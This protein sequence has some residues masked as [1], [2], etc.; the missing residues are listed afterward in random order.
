MPVSRQGLN[1]CF[2]QKVI[3]L[4][5]RWIN[6]SRT[7]FACHL[8]PE[9]YRGSANKGCQSS[10]SLVSPLWSGGEC[11]LLTASCVSAAPCSSVQ[12]CTPSSKAAVSDSSC[13]TRAGLM[14]QHTFRVCAV[15]LLQ[16]EVRMCS[17]TAEYEDV[18]LSFLSPAISHSAVA[19]KVCMQRW[20]PGI[21]FFFLTRWSAWPLVC[22]CVQE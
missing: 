9:D 17:H 19:Y 11:C 16:Y 14:E 21:F 22:A 12:L 8:Q 10:Q 5:R 4:R 13:V 6:H 15:S 2:T 3:G 18:P 7:G 20:A 1:L